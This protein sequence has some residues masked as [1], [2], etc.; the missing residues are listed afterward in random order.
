MT[1]SDGSATWCVALRHKVE[2]SM[3]ARTREERRMRTLI[4]HPHQRRRDRRALASSRA[5]PSTSISVRMMATR[6]RDW[7]VP[8]GEDEFQQE[9]G[10]KAIAAAAAP[11]RGGC[12]Q[13]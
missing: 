13:Q 7:K 2:I 3:A 6:A 11:C 5:V 8:A 9:Q 4:R 12:Q 10:G 1:S